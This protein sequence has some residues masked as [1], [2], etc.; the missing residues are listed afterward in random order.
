MKVVAD[1]DVVGLCK[2]LGEEPEPLIDWV[3][4]Y[5]RQSNTKKISAHLPKFSKGT[6]EIELPDSTVTQL[7]RHCSS[8]EHMAQL[9][10]FLLLVGLTLGGV[11]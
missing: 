11:E 8:D 4:G 1:K 6:I 3:L 10:S 7:K 2:Q 9:V 5:V